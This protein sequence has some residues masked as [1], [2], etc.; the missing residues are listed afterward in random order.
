M[1]VYLFFRIISME[2]YH[3]VPA[4]QYFDSHEGNHV[5]I[6]EIT[7][8]TKVVQELPYAQNII[9]YSVLFATYDRVNTGNVTIQLS[10]QTSGNIYFLKSYSANEFADN[11]YVNLLL[12]GT[13][14][15]VQDKVMELTVLSDSRPYEA[16]TIW[17]TEED[18]VP[19][20]TLTVGGALKKGDLCIK[21]I[22]K[23]PLLRTFAIYILSILLILVTGVVLW[24]DGGRRIETTCVAL[25][26][27]LGLLYLFVM[28]PLSIPDEQH[29]YQSAYQLSN[30]LTLHWD[31]LELG[32]SSDF[33]YSRLVGH[34]NV[35]SAYERFMEEI[36]APGITG[37]RVLIPQLLSLE[38]PPEYLPQAIGIALARLTGANFLITFY[39]GRLCNLFFYVFCLYLAVCIAPRFK[40]LFAVL[41]I[42]PMALH[43]A[44]SYSYDGFVNSMAL[45]LI[46]LILRAVYTD[47][48]FTQKDLWTITIVGLLLAPAKLVYCPL[49]LLILL[50]PKERFRDRGHKIR[51]I[52]LMMCLV[53]VPFCLLELKT[54]MGMVAFSDETLNWEG[55]HNYTTAFILHHPRSTV[56]VFL[57]TFS[58]CA[59]S[60]F[61]QSIGSVLS[62]MTLV[63]P[64]RIT[65]CYVI[66]TVFSALG[67]VGNEAGIRLRERVAFLSASIAVM[68]LVMLSM[69]LG[70]TSDTSSVI[71][72][73]QGRYFIPILTLLFLQFNH[74]KIQI[75]QPVEQIVLLSAMFLNAAAI[76]YVLRY[77]IGF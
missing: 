77:T 21:I 41:G 68:F 7:K 40:L 13:S 42:S 36:N 67:H 8:K 71:Q 32:D 62:G 48:S 49:L 3:S 2:V 37:E 12:N 74:R 47:G 29:H 24:S 72:G 73:V 44:A 4:Y 39:L 70:W 22:Q 56:A 1:T 16:L 63:L 66:V 9:G 65:W 45:L 19:E 59:L 31:E 27:S 33:D 76:T 43:Q 55:K 58:R 64:A 34:Y 10:G 20:C 53:F 26:F 18:S 50:I 52:T 5:P 14:V 25:A 61:E 35:A 57:R 60:W 28:T 38:Y 51:T 6:G 15:S 46:A 75:H 23:T 69:F 54:V 11:S 30:V 17:S